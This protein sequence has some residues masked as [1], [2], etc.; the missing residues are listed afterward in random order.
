MEL[1]IFNNFRQDMY[2]CKSLIII[3]IIYKVYLLLNNIYILGLFL[4]SIF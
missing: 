3:K 4:Y 2:N 1:R